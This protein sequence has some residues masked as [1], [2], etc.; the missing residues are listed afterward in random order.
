MAVTTADPVPRAVIDEIVGS[1]GF[2]D[3]RTIAL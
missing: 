3:G 2:V 1:E